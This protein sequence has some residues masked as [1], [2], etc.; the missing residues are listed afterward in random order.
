MD[1]IVEISNVEVIKSTPKALLCLL[2]DGHEV[3]VPRSVIDEESEVSD[4]G[5][6]GVLIVAGWF[7]EKEELE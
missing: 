2:E 5:D 7:A 6:Q 3:W 4:D 1:R